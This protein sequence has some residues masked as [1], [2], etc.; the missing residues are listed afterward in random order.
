MFKYE[1]CICREIFI[2]F[3]K[4]NHLLCDECFEDENIHWT[5][6]IERQCQAMFDRTFTHDYL[7]GIFNKG[8]V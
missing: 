7:P 2:K 3:Q 4:G 1:C 5:K 8:M 6:K